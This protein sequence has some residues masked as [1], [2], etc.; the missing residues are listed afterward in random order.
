[1]AEITEAC[2]FCGK[3]SVVYCRDIVAYYIDKKDSPVA[4]ESL[5]EL[6]PRCEEHCG[7][8]TV[9]IYNGAVWGIY[10]DS[11]EELLRWVN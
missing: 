2:V 5:T 7:S 6:T 3:P 9:C 4:I 11:T 8:V 1:M 10:G